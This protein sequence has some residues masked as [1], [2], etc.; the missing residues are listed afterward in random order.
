MRLHGV[1]LVSFPLSGHGRG[2]QR[3]GNKM[4]GLKC[5]GDAIREV[6]LG[7]S[8]TISPDALYTV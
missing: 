2:R 3:H 7:D 5:A 1:L 6:G 8:E 4:V